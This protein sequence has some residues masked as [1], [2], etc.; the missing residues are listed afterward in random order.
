MAQQ[1]RAV[2]A[3]AEGPGLA[4]GTHMATY[5]LSVIPV[6]E[7]LMAFSDLPRAP[8]TH[9]LHMYTCRQSTHIK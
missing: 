4:P 5:K 3:L 2:A 8:G 9:A 7:D 1:F 6:P